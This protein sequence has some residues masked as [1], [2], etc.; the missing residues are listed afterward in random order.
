MAQIPKGMLV[1]GP[2][3]P[4]CRGLCH[5]LFDYCKSQ[6]NL[7]TWVCQTSPRSLSPTSL[8]SLVALQKVTHHIPLVQL[9][10][11][12]DGEDGFW[13]TSRLFHQRLF[14]KDLG[15]PKNDMFFFW[16]RPW[17]E[18]WVPMNGLLIFVIIVLWVN[19]LQFL[20]S[21]WSMTP[22]ATFSWREEVLFDCFFLSHFHG[23][24]T[25]WWILSTIAAWLA[26]MS[27]SFFL[28][29]FVLRMLRI[30]RHAR[31][32]LEHFPQ[33]SVSVGQDNLTDFR[34]FVLPKAS[35]V[36]VFQQKTPNKK[37]KQSNQHYPKITK[38]RL[39]TTEKSTTTKPATKSPFF[40]F[41]PLFLRFPNTF[42]SNF[43]G[44]FAG[45]KSEPLGVDGWLKIFHLWDIRNERN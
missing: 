29:I 18:E 31:L 9:G 38:L 44:F 28:K 30:L 35:H 34:I 36:F 8:H 26:D 3:K 6:Q 16:P 2:Y 22:K 11:S 40:W 43:Q 15:P 1:K 39:P 17:H 32:Y 41:H 13:R 23:K 37:P 42:L 19:T 12:N 5:L 10:W 33:F 27:H 7:T 4:I 21:K 20:G 24:R 45:W 14:L 25:V